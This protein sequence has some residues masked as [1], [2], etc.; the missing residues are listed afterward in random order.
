MVVHTTEPMV[1][2]TDNQVSMKM[3]EVGLRVNTYYT[4]NISVWNIGGLSAEIFTFSE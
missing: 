3:R 4:V 2:T 1:Y